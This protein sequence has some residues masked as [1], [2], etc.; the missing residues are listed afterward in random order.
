[1]NLNAGAA[2]LTEKHLTA[3]NE[4]SNALAAAAT[5]IKRL[6]PQWGPGVIQLLIVANDRVVSVMNYG[7]ASIARYIEKHGPKEPEAPAA[8]LPPVELPE[9]DQNSPSGEV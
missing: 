8:E 2:K 6:N 1:M 9:S 4:A 7:A 3:L 5:T